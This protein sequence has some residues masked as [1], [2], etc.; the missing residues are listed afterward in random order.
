MITAGESGGITEGNHGGNLD[1][2]L[3]IGF[4]GFLNDL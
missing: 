3:Q 4:H 1:G 2:Q